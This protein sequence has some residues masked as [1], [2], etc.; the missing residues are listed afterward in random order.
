MNLKNALIVVTFTS[1]RDLSN[2]ASDTKSV[3]INN[4]ASLITEL[5]NFP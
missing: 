2:F 3:A 1:N 5:K 4:I